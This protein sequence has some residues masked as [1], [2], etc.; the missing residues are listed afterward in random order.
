MIYLSIYLGVTLSFLALGL[1][2]PFSK[3]LRTTILDKNVTGIDLKIFRGL[4]LFFFIS[5][6]PGITLILPMFLPSSKQNFDLSSNLN[7]LLSEGSPILLALASFVIWSFVLIVSFRSSRYFTK[8]A[9]KKYFRGLAN[10]I[11][12]LA[13]VLSLSSM[14]AIWTNQPNLVFLAGTTFFLGFAGWIYSIV[15]MDDNCSMW[16]KG[17]AG[18]AAVALGICGPIWACQSL[19]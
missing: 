17:L 18:F 16:W 7:G 13:V 2:C 12:W 5:A 9:M 1:A 8:G 10:P 19:S 4:Y 3:F 14:S 6:I 11:G 15:V